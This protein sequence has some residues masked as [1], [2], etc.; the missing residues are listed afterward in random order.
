MPD[1]FTLS[2]ARRIAWREARASLTPFLFVILAVSLGVGALTGVRGFS[3]SF[4]GMLLRDAR[5][6]MAADMTVRTFALPTPAQQS[7]LVKLAASGVEQTRVT[8]TVS[9]L[10]T[11]SQSTP[12]LVSIKAVDPGVYPFYGSLKLAPALNLRQALQPDTVAVSTDLLVRLDIKTGD[13]VKLGEASFRIAAVVTAEPDRMAG[14]LNVGPRILMSR[15][16]LDRTGLITPGSRAAQR[17]LFR[18]KP[19]SIPIARARAELKEAFPGAQI[20][21]YRE[22]H[23]LI[24]RGL[25]RA[26]TFLSLVSLI[27]LFVGAL[28]VAMAMHSHLQRKMDTIAVMKS[29]G[30]R[31]GQIMAIY[32]LQTLMLGLLGGAG[33]MVLGLAVQGIFP[34]L[35]ARYFQIDPGLH[36]DPGSALQGLATGV[37]STLLFTL[38]PLLGIRAIRPGIILRR[39]ME[40]AR[41]H[42]R[43]RLKNGR[44]AALAG[45]VIAAGILAIVWWLSESLRLGL[46]F[47]GGLVVSILILT[48][49]AGG[50]L[51]LLRRAAHWCRRALPATLRHG[52]ANI[53]RPGNQASA[54]LV[55]LGLG[56]MFTLTVYLVQNSMLIQIANSAPPGMPNVFLINITSLE[57]DGIAGMLHRRKG[58]EGPA[59]VIPIVS[60][61]MLRI[62]GSPVQDLPLQGSARRFRQARSVTWS[63]TLN[64]QAVVTAGKFWGPKDTAQS[65]G[66]QLCAGEDAA[67]SLPIK[68]GTRIDWVSGARTFTSQVACVYRSEAV[69]IG[70]N[71]DFVFI[72]GA[73]DGIPALHFA[74]IRMQP[75]M[76]AQFQRDVFRR[77]PAVTVI[78]GA[79][80]LA[81]IQ[82][83]VDQIAL[84]VR[85]ISFFAILAGAIILASSVAGTR[86][87]RIREV[88]ILKTLG[89]TRRRIAG[90]FSVE[91]LLLGA[92]AGILGSLLAT[93]FSLLLLKRLFQADYRFEPWPHLAAILLTAMLANA[94]GWLASHRILRQKPLE[95]LR[96]SL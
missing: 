5:Q 82:E 9:M 49:V 29:I 89:A 42:W 12:A 24:T 28:G 17:V 46:Y 32:T 85:F 22:T 39:E 16:G 94:A 43:A 63:G 65:A 35:I 47:A 34:R 54:L 10:S 53:Y 60:A 83:V 78:N 26:T 57:R 40:E 37:L 96:D 23:P 72:P 3:Q 50:V 21:D 25:D 92:A 66:V 52:L 90:I 48:A 81:I 73:L 56:V 20:I 11:S 4:R 88:V 69:R 14:S 61:R 77:F 55:A 1:R 59:E 76:V 74:A 6:L 68:P 44:P 45:S 33:G 84:V 8:E 93:G 41:P 91:F 95:A 31:S 58:I 71:L 75:A 13:A 7:V 19:N 38:P 2:M 62:D 79:D 87:R 51:A 64:P 36:W 15:A 30:A 18:F 86:F 67:K 80:V 27:A 70:S